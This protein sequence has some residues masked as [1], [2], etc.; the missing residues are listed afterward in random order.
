MK[1]PDNQP[2]AKQEK[3]KCGITVDLPVFPRNVPQEYL[4]SIHHGDQGSRAATPA[5]HVS[6]WKGIMRA[7]LHHGPAQAG[8]GLAHYPSNY[9]AL[10]G[11][12]VV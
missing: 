3:G 2:H 8:V 11:F 4:L 12:E 7:Q 1:H 5:L 9:A 6:L 10:P